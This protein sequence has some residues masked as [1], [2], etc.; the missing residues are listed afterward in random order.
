MSSV[1]FE[2]ASFEELFEKKCPKNLSKF[3][4]FI[5]FSLKVKVIFSCMATKVLRVLI[6]FTKFFF[7]LI[8]EFVL[9]ICWKQIK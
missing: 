9:I 5:N 1:L 6:L 2:S 4:I 8:I 3:Q 7:N